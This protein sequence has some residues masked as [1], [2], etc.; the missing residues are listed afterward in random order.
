VLY[1]AVARNPRVPGFIRFNT[2]QAILLD[3]VLVVLSLAF[4]VLLENELIERETT[5]V[6][7]PRPT[8]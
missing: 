5:A 3:I 2:L 4:N 6:S 8:G 1:L 7:Q